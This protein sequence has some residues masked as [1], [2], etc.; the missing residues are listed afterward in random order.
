MLESLKNL[1]SRTAPATKREHA[2]LQRG[3]KPASQDFRAVTICPGSSACAGA[4]D[5]AGHR[6]LMRRAPILPLAN[7]SQSRECKCRFRR[8]ADRREG[9]RRL[10]G[11]AMA[12]SYGGGEGRK[13]LNRR[14]SER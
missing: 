6:F 3:K 13:R 1:L 5:L 10:E 11:S 2:P 12:R 4:K 9:D 14:S 8:T 7:C